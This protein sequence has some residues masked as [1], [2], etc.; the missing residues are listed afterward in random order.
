MKNI[1]KHIRRLTKKRP[2]ELVRVLWNLETEA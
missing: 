1:I 2:R